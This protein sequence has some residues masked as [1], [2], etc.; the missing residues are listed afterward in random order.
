M[1]G[2]RVGDARNIQKESQKRCEPPEKKNTKILHVARY[3]R[4]TS[5]RGK[6]KKIEI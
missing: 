4:Q 5:K 1:V 6:N 3:T 2:F